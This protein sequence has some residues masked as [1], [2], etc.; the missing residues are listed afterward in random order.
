VNIGAEKIKREEN[1]VKMKV[2]ADKTRLPIK[3][4]LD[5]IEDGAMRQARNL[6]NLPFAFKHI[7]LM[8]DC[9]QGYGMPIGGVL[10][11]ENIIVPNAVGVDIGCGMAFVQTNIPAKLLRETETGQ[12]NLAH[13][14]INNIMRSVPVGFN[15]QQE[16]QES[17]CLDNAPYRVEHLE[18]GLELIPEIEKA[19]FSMG[20]MGGNN[21][22]IELQED[23][24]GMVAIMLHS[25]SRNLG[26][27]ICD[28]FNKLAVE[29]NTKWFSVIPKEWGLAFFPVDSREGQSYIAWMNLAQ[30]FAMENRQQMMDISKNTLFDMVHKYINSEMVFEQSMNVNAHHN[31]ATIEHHFGKNVWVHRKGAIRA[32][33]GELGIIPGAM[34]SFSYI[35]EGLGNKDSFMS[36]SHGAGRRMGRKE[37]GRQFTAE[38]TLADLKAKGVTLGKHKKD[39]VAE[40]SVWAY[41]DIDEVINNELDLIKPI[42]KLKAIAVIKG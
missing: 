21:H 12:G 25:G 26:K 42:K 39:N 40:E 29:I 1:R 2:E 13:I 15:H 11:T 6:A 34:G 28:Y 4:W 17:I 37:A 33:E 22:F 27:K 18:S 35:V 5:E 8:P 38:D 19:Y 10:A 9:H 3:M 24:N 36:C 41:K 30:E 7:A 31:Y 20:T 23:E 16:K 32:R 14:V